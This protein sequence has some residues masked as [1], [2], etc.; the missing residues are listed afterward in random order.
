VVDICIHLTWVA[1]KVLLLNQVNGFRRAYNLLVFINM[2]NESKKFGQ[3]L[4][5][6]LDADIE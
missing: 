5:S 6:V 1:T 3:F 4:L 2:C